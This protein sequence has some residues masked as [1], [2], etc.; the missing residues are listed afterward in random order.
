M[1][2]G[3]HAAK[4]I[5]ARLAQ[6][7]APPFR[8]HDKGTMATVGR[9][10]AVVDLGFVRFSGLAAWLTWLFVHLLYLVGYRSRLMVAIQWAFQYSTFNR[11]ARLITG[12][13]AKRGPEGDEPRG[14]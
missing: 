7:S 5:A 6:Q 13:P 11:G 1:Q 8:Y 2:H 12:P 14:H 4:V 9:A 10:A 3:W